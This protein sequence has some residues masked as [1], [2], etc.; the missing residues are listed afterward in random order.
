MSCNLYNPNCRQVNPFQPRCRGLY[1][2]YTLPR[3]K[4]QCFNVL[5]RVCVRP[6]RERTELV[7]AISTALHLLSCKANIYFYYCFSFCRTCRIR[8]IKNE[9]CLLVRR[10]SRKEVEMTPHFF[11]PHNGSPHKCW[12]LNLRSQNAHVGRKCRKRGWH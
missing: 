6:F 2:R 11:F 7:G 5:H 4:Q 10:S 1:S 12:P 9:V 8:I 3:W